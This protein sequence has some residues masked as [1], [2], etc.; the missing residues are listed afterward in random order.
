M[1]YLS[2]LA[3]ALPL[4]L[5][6]AASGQTTLPAGAYLPVHLT[7]EI[8]AGHT[9]PNTPVEAR[10][11]QRIPLA[12]HQFLPSNALLR[13][14]VTQSTFSAGSSTLT[15]TFTSILQSG[16]T[17]PISVRAVAIANFTA[18][19]DVA[20]PAARSTDT[21]DSST[22]NMTTRQVGGDEVY[23]SAWSGPLIDAGGQT[24]GSAD[25]QGVYTDDTP[26]P[27]ALGAFSTAAQG[28]YG[29]ARK[30]SLAP[31]GISI[32]SPGHLSL[33]VNDQLLL[34][35]STIEIR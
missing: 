24:V 7:H 33:H 26:V 31:E 13:G 16:Q 12:N 15:L 20:L 21:D 1:R 18:V 19:S 5:T 23:R 2:L 8:T 25:F 11:T 30:A 28:L 17:V 9:R 32:T 35:L 4:A 34:V 29:Y 27:R 10:T 22:S 6:L 3:A 14:S